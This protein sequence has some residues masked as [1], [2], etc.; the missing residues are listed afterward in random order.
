MNK[1]DL[2]GVKPNAGIEKQYLKKL[3]DFSRTMNKSFKFWLRD[4]IKENI[5][6]ISFF[7]RLKSDFESLG[8]FWEN[9]ANELSQ[10]LPFEIITKINNENQFKN[11]KENGF[12]IQK[13]TPE[14]IQAVIN[15]RIDENIA[16]IKTIPQKDIMRYKS[17]IFNN[18][19]NFNKEGLTQNISTIN[20][21]LTGAQKIAEYEV[22]RIVRD[23][24]KKATEQLNQAKMQN[25]GYEFY[26]WQTMNDDRVSGKPGGKYKGRPKKGG[27]YHLNK[28]YYRYD[29]PTAI[30]SVEHGASIKGTC[31]Q[32]V[33]CRCISKPVYVLPHQEMV[34]IKDDKIGDYYELREKSPETIAKEKAQ[35]E[36]ENQTQNQKTEPKK[37][38]FSMIKNLINKFKKKK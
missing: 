5:S 4:L 9:K 28:K 33:N 6:E 25:L 15:A 11:K 2:K 23:Q 18:I 8:L 34:L 27:H 31:G 30:I 21:Q 10:T 16:L 35:K 20:K 7:N 13:I 1:H 3:L 26:Q 22:R 36:K 38:F 17:I 37:G 29:T 19:Q 32:R 24:I 14:N 12:N